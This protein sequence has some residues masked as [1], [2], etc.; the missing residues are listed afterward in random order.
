MNYKVIKRGEPG[1]SGGGTIKYY[2]SPHYSGEID[3]FNISKKLSSR[4]TV[5]RSDAVAVLS[6]FVDLIAEELKEGKI[7]K[8]GN[9]GS[10]RISISSKGEETVEEVSSASI[11]GSKVLFRPAPI[12]R[13]NLSG[14]TFEKVKDVK[15]NPDEDESPAAA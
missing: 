6:G 4:S 5:T 13:E 14:L 9:L 2:A 11:K 12:F 7:V 10:F 3:L 15:A 8:L 1:V